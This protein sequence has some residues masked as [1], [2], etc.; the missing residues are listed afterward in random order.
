ME[1]FK[2]S[3]SISKEISS[4]K[5][6]GISFGFVPTMGA[7]H[8]GHASLIRKSKS[9]NIFT[10]VSIFVNPTQFNNPGDLEKYPRTEKEDLKL[11]E[12]LGVD[13]VFMPEISE[14]YPEK[15]L[16]IFDFNGLDT[17]MEGQ[18]RP[19]HFNGVAQVVSKLFKII[20]PD[21]AY[22]GK[23][24]FQQLAVI[25]M[26]NKKYFGNKNIKIVAC[27]IVRE[28]DGLAMSSRNVRLSPEH[29][30]SAVNI[31]QTLFKYQKNNKNYTVNQL[32]NLVTKEID[33][34][35][36]LKTE[37]FEIVDNTTLKPV[38]QIIPGKTTG[39]IAVFAGDV[40]L[41]DNVS[42]S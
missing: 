37:Y 33:A 36:N 24:D 11:I 15:D 39:C 2:Y 30:K 4:L 8:E 22:F 17:V 12:D 9:E 32:K 6:H 35:K 27:D 25:R 28:T 5:N 14:I 42:F 34:D 21:K 41:I 3:A 19:G 38:E 1:I 31:S 18:F 13:F 7:L 40:R 29:R 20:Q 26:M 10:V 23:K 16:R